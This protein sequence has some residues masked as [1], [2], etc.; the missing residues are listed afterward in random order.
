MQSAK[1][2]TKAILKSLEETGE[3]ETPEAAFSEDRFWESLQ[4]NDYCA[5]LA[6]LPDRDFVR[7]KLADLQTYLR[8]KTLCAAT[9]GFGPRYLHSTGQLHKGGSANGL[10]VIISV[11][12]PSGLPV[13]GEKYS[14]EQLEMAQAMGDFETL[15]SKGQRVF[16]YALENLSE[17]S[18]ATLMLRIKHDVRKFS[19]A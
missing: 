9:L 15:Q 13:P 16:H 2:K 7:K 3:I 6:F 10:F 18:L 19:K 1:D 8:E 17:E 5:L 14:F 4:K 12:H 11:S